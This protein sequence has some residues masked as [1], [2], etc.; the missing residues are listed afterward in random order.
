MSTAPVVVVLTTDE[1]GRPPYLDDLAGHM[2]IRL[3]DAAGLSEALPGAQVLYLWDFFSPAV[4]GAWAAADA[5]EWIHVAA[6]G[7]DSLLFDDLRTSEVVV[8][9]ARGV[10]DR[11]IAEFVLASLLARVK[12]LHESRDLQRRHQWQ[13]RE[14][15]SLAGSRALV[16]GTGAIAREIGRLLAAVGVQVRG[17][18]RQPTVDDP[19]F[20]EV[21]SSLDLPAHVGWADHVVNATPLT[22]ATSGLFDAK[23]FAAMKPG[24]HFVNIGR[25][26]SVIEEDLLAALHAGHLGAASLDVFDVEPLPENSPIWEA[27][28]LVVSAH[29][30]GDV[31]GWTDALARQFVQ[32]AQRWLRGAALVNVVDK[33]LGYVRAE[34]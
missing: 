12:L 29:M 30:S 21:V 32:N 8:T 2:T 7:V 5:L 17:A 18:G 26:A 15:T 3:T 31:V 9:N 24:S 25:G 4:A 20:G 19:D 6:A 23:V 13:H 1:R 28:G 34:R 11:P 27:P 22:A 33:D 14:T 16:V 10:F